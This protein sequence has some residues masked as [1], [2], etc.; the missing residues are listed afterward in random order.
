MNDLQKYLSK[1]LLATAALLVSASPAWAQVSLGTASSFAVLGGTTVTTSASTINGD[2]GSGGAV[3]LTDSAINGNL[4]YTGALVNAGSTISGTQ[5]TPLNPQVITDLNSAWTSVQSLACDFNLT[6]TIA[7]PVTLAP[8]VY[9]SDTAL[10]GA[11]VLTLD[12]GG[13]A[14]A[15][16]VFKIGAA[17]TGTGFSVVMA[18]G[19]QACNV[20]WVPGA[21]VTMTTSAFSGNILAG[22]T[23]PAGGSITMTGGT[24]AGQ[25]LANTAVTMTGVNVIGCSALPVPPSGPP[26]TCKDKD[27][28]HDGHDGHDKDH[29]KCNQGVGNGPEDCDPGKSDVHWPF[30]GSN[31][32]HEGDKP[33]DPG[34]KGGRK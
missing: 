16:W 21:D 2:V 1:S 18:N 32:E 9:C 19:G 23:A 20:F 31:D 15:V 34:R 25:A 3:T 28:D 26:S 33:G 12:A 5:T 8:G 7:G 10:T 14:N 17:I 13:H 30:K 22:S 4:V 6:A 27:R 29:K 24:L 11:G